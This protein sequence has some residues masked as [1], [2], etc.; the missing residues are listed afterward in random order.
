MK[1]LSLAMVGLVESK[2]ALLII[3]VQDCFLKKA[4]TSSGKDGTLGVD[5][6]SVIDKLNSI[7]NN[8][9]CLFDAFVRTQDYHPAG[10]MSFASSHNLPAMA[11]LPTAAGGLGK[12][13]LQIM[14]LNGTTDSACCATLQV[15]GGNA[16]KAECAT[17]LCPN[18]TAPFAYSTQASVKGNKAC[19]VCRDTPNKCFATQQQM[20]PDHCLSTTGG[21]AGFPSKL[22][23]LKSDTIIQKGTNL[24]VDAY[25]GFMDNTETYKTDLDAKLIAMGVKEL[26]IAGIA[27][28]F[29]VIET[30]KD[31]LIKKTANYKVTVIKDATAA[32]IP[33]SFESSLKAMEAAG[34][35]IKTTADILNMGCLTTDP[36]SSAV[37]PALGSLL[38]FAASLSFL[39]M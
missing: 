29:C 1:F 14:C 18:L 17:K 31:A 19:T 9:S 5:G 26:Y 38:L 22:K 36:S 12:G 7:R 11:H 8:K 33:A 13:G 15:H 28:D 23:V 10:H 32:V 6:C 39:N 2:R 21:D 20:W 16:T 30:V 4:C 35:T 25:S 27:T 37:R 3:D 34:A 24:Y